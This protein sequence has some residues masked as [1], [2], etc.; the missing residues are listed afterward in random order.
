MIRVRGEGEWFSRRWQNGPGGWFQRHDDA[1]RKKRFMIFN[2]EQVGG[3]AR[4]TVQKD[5]KRVL[6]DGWSEIKLRRYISFLVRTLYVRER[7]SYVYLNFEPEL[8][9]RFE[10]RSEARWLT[11]PARS[12]IYLANYCK[13]YHKSYNAKTRVFGL[14]L[15]SQAVC[16]GLQSLWRSWLRMLPLW[17]K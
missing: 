12:S 2:E 9:H 16:I 17:V 1:Y 5:D 3:R 8:L 13:Y 6:Q 7:S 10:N 15:F 4:M 11:A 14:H